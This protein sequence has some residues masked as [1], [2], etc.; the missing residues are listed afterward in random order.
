MRDTFDETNE[1]LRII[2][3]ALHKSLCELCGGDVPYHLDEIC[4]DNDKVQSRRRTMTVEVWQNVLYDTCR[5]SINATTPNPV[6]NLQGKPWNVE[7]RTITSLYN[8]FTGG[9]GGGGKAKKEKR[10]RGRSGTP[11]QQDNS[12]N[13]STEEAS[14]RKTLVL[15]S[16]FGVLRTV[17]SSAEWGKLILPRM[18]EAMPTTA[19]RGHVS[20]SGFLLWTSPARATALYQVG[21][22]PCGTCEAWPKGGEKGLWWHQQEQHDVHHASATACAAATRLGRA[23]M[24]YQ[25]R[26]TLQELCGVTN[27]NNKNQSTD[28]DITLDASC[29]ADRRTLAFEY[30]KSGDLVKLQHAIAH[31]WIDPTKDVDTRGASVLLWAAGGGHLD[32]LRYLVETCGCDPRQPQRQY[33]RGFA[34]R[35]ALHWAC[36]NGHLS[37]VKYLLEQC[38]ADA[39]KDCTA[40]GTTAVGW[41]A[42]QGQQD[43]LEYLW[44]CQETLG[45]DHNIMQVVNKFGCNALLWAAQGTATPATMEWLVEVTGCAI[46]HTNGNGHSILHKAAQRNRPDIAAWF[47]TYVLKICN[48]ANQD[49]RSILILLGPDG[50]GCTPSDLA[51]IEGHQKLALQVCETERVLWQYVL[52]ELPDLSWPFERNA[53]ALPN[54]YGPGCGVARL[55]DLY[56]REN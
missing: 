50:E 26:Q 29:P 21:R 9:G 30:A 2:F 38:G 46:T 51:G 56:Q 14:N 28:M 45:I 54:E 43:I 4:E 42:W 12:Q 10:K 8:R 5:S 41:A 23:V 25:P 22:R 47:E 6:E 24:V 1:D 31:G 44:K 35:T 48:D 52:N 40:D 3:D 13:H 55:W 33:R 34:G 11:V 27:N 36:R 53:S 17:S 19:W 20:P 15:T 39:L 49:Y 16:D 37:A 18:E 32:I 7:V